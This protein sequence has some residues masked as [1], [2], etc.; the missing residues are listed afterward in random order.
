MDLSSNT[1]MDLVSDTN[2]VMDLLTLY[3]DV[4]K[5]I[6]RFLDEVFD[7]VVGT[8]KPPKDKTSTPK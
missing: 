5:T 1:D 4:D 8:A 6:A 7:I 3:S 2:T